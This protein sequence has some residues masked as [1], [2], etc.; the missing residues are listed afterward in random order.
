MKNQF[1]VGLLVVAAIS[2]CVAGPASAGPGAQVSAKDVAALKQRDKALT[3]KVAALEKTV[4]AQEGM[5]SQAFERLDGQE[6]LI[7][8]LGQKV[9]EIKG[10]PLGG[11]SFDQEAGRAIRRHDDMLADHEK[12][13]KKLG[14]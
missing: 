8:Q 7:Q 14:G 5:I 10:S 11:G 13:I 9:E 6:Q 1:L 2:L 3:A 4:A 12:R